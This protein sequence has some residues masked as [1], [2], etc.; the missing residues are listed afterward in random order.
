[1]SFLGQ[2]ELFASGSVPPGWVPCQG[3]QMSIPQNQ[4]LFSLLGTTYGGDGRMH[5]ALPDL[6]GRVPV[7]A[8][9][10]NYLGT[11]SGE[12]HHTLSGGEMPAHSHAL[13]T[14]AVSTTGVGSTPSAATVLGRSAGDVVPG[15]TPTFTAN[16]YDTVNP[17]AKLAPQTIGST[18]GGQPHENRMPSLALN[19]CI[20][21]DPHG[22]YP[23]R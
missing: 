3:Q 17:S 23:G 12:E 16:L 8:G 13:M 22:A 7:G 18:G 15:G 2:I 5:F 20:Y 6:R 19:F 21:V 11:W 1:M 4:A 10:V 9:P 14:D